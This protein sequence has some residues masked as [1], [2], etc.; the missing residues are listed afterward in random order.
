MYSSEDLNSIEIVELFLKK[1]D[2][3][4]DEEETALGIILKMPTINLSVSQWHKVHS[5]H[6]YSETCASGRPPVLRG[7]SVMSQRCLRNIF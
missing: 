7:H 2:V 5:I 4:S 1:T 6:N 3:V